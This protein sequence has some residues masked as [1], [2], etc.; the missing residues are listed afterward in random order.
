MNMTV[1]LI[2]GCSDKCRKELWMGRLRDKFYRGQVGQ[3]MFPLISQ[4]GLT[5]LLHPR[6]QV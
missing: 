3:E 6:N 2:A 4:Q 1:E 5:K